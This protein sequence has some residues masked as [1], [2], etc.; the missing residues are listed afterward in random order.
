MNWMHFLLDI[1]IILILIIGIWHFRT[2][3]GAR[4]GNLTAAFALLCAFL[5]MLMRNNILEPETVIISLFIG[6]VIGWIVAIKVNMNQLPS[7][8]AFQNGAGGM[9]AFIVSFVELTRGGAS[10]TTTSKVAGL[11]GLI[12]GS[13]TFSASMVASGKLANKLRQTPTTFPAHRWILGLNLLIVVVL[14]ILSWTSGNLFNAGYLLVLISLSVAMGIIFS[15]R[16][17]GADMPV[18]ISFLNAATGLTAALCGMIIK[19][20]LLIA[21]GTT[22]AASGSILTHV[23]CKAMNRNFFKLFFGI[24]QK[25]STKYSDRAS[26]NVEQPNL[27]EKSSSETGLPTGESKKSKDLAEMAPVMNSAEKI[28]IIPGYGMALAHAQFKVCELATKFEELGKDVKFAIHPVAGRMPGHMNVV[29]A[30]ADIE[31][32]KLYEMDDINP[33]FKDTDL[34]LIIGACDVVNSAAI[35][36]EGTPISGMPILM[37]HEAK[38]VIVCNLNEKPGYSGVENPLYTN[39][40]AILFLGDAKKTVSQLV[41]MLG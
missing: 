36:V 18:M 1:L 10:L 33:E 21:C 22:V 9:A 15:M 40:K 7:M 28:I 2:P 20:R 11:L 26:Q 27:V 23:M 17:G 6:T 39:D 34:V 12:V 3:R 16:I 30:E 29:L 8:V 31:Y 19:N 4:V 14:S 38:R 5:L 35:S 37:A 41:E 13:I 32:D 25:I 24:Q